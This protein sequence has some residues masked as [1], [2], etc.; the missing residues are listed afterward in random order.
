M[1]KRYTRIPTHPIETIKADMR[2]LHEV[3]VSY[4]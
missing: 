1:D 3:I 4:D 2:P